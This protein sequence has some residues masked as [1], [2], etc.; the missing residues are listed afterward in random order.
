MVLNLTPA[1]YASGVVGDF[2]LCL[3][4]LL[5]SFSGDLYF[6]V[7]IIGVYLTCVVVGQTI[8]EGAV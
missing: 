3:P 2:M 8:E 5:V 7:L 1:H 6:D 4:S